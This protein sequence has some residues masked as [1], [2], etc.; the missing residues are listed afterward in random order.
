[1]DEPS[2]IVT[3]RMDTTGRLEATIIKKLNNYI[4][5]RL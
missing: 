3:G 4:T 5:F 1:M 2:Y